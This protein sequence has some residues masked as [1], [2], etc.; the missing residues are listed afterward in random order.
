MSSAPTSFAITS[1]ILFSNPSRFLLEKGRLSGSPQ[2]RN[3]FVS[4][5]QALPTRDD[6]IVI[7]S[8]PVSITNPFRMFLPLPSIVPCDPFHPQSYLPLSE[9]DPSLLRSLLSMAASIGHGAMREVYETITPL[10]S[11]HPVGWW[12][13]D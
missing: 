12:V 1:A 13:S 2:T 5:P 3:S 7:R 11:Y 9:K 6:E 10:S 8:N 4:A